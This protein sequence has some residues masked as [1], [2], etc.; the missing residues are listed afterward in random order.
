MCLYRHLV[1]SFVSEQTWRQD[2]RR[3]LCDDLRS[4]GSAVGKSGE[5]PAMIHL[6]LRIFQCFLLIK[7]HTDAGLIIHISITVLYHRAA[8]EYCLLFFGESGELL[9]SEVMAVEIQMHLR[10]H[11]DGRQV[12][13]TVP[14]SSY[15]IGFTIVCKFSR[16][17]DSTDIA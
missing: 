5:E 2:D 10:S 9:D 16:R 1:F 8:G 15:S 17:S 7:V 11:T 14:C 12:I 13:G 6:N 3:G 4:H